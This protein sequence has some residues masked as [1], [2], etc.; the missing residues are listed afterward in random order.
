MQRRRRG[1]VLEQQPRHLAVP[2]LDRRQQR[3]EAS[4]GLVVG[5]LDRGAEA[6]E[7]GG[8]GGAALVGALVQRRVAVRV[9]R[10]DLPN[11]ASSRV[12]R[13]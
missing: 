6:E 9:L 13:P 7:Q 11:V 8:G 10:V 2:E 12:L 4:L 5:R 1:A 3:R